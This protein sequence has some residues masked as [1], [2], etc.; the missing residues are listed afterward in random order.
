MTLTPPLI[1]AMAG[2]KARLRRERVPSPKELQLHMPVA[3][4]LRQHCL[5]PWTH[6]PA[7][8]ERPIK[9][10]TKL[11]Q[12]GLQRGWA[13]FLLIAPSGVL[14]CLELKRAGKD[15]TPAQEDF[16]DQC[17][18]SNVP[19]ETAQ[20]MDHVLLALE[21]WGCLRVKYTRRIAP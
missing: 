7:G 16:R 4:L 2:G 20:T 15:L 11:K 12:M 9:A 14:H 13:D 8:E 5:W 19:Y 6:F 18:A 1:V 21:R 3:K 17:I 10:A